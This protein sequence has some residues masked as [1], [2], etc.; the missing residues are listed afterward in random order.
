MH[1]VENAWINYSGLS[2]LGGMGGVPPSA[3]NLIL[4]P[5]IF[6]NWNSKVFK[7]FK[8]KMHHFVTSFLRQFFENCKDG[9]DMGRLE[10]VMHSE[11]QFFF[12]IAIVY[13]FMELVLQVVNPFM[14]GGNKKSKKS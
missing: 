2:V 13:I 6:Q 14:P 10:V 3:E 4:P 12:V 9:N 7:R 5:R 8:Y 1:Q 11:I